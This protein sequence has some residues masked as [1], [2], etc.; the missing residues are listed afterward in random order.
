MNKIMI[1]GNLGKA[2]EMRYTP[3]GKAVTSFSVA[4][5]HKHN[6]QAGEK[7]SETTWFRCTAWNQQADI[8]NQYL[9]KGSKVMVEGSLVAD[10]MTGGPKL[11]NKQDGTQ[12]ASFEISV[13]S[14]EFLSTLETADGAGPT[15]EAQPNEDEIPF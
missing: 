11:W 8:C 9:K 12:G 3:S 14:V 10:P 4:V 6:N 1:I 7:V 13:Q 15:V 2:P 5:N